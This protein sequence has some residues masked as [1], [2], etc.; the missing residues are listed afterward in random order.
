MG[1]NK[2]QGLA[3]GEIVGD[4]RIEEW[5]IRAR[6]LGERKGGG[7]VTWGRKGESPGEKLT[8]TPSKP[9]SLLC[10]GFGGELL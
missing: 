2:K 10:C 4:K 1:S 5:D 3:Q 9:P 6:G 8:E 7:K